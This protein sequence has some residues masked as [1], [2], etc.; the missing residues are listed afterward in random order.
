MHVDNV[1]SYSVNVV[2]KMMLDVKGNVESR[3][4]CTTASADLA[5][6]SESELD[7]NI[8]WLHV[9]TD[10]TWG[11]KTIYDSGEKQIFSYC[12]NV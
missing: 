3:Q 7:I 8:S 4:I 5:L 10:K 1:V 2:P 12:A 9:H 11:P 6:T